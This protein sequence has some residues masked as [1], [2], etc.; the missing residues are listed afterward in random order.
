MI[1]F[2][3]SKRKKIETIERI[4]NYHNMFTPLQVIVKEWG[5]RAKEDQRGKGAKV[6]LYESHQGSR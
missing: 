3:T 5:Q 1:R 6:L 2:K 4:T